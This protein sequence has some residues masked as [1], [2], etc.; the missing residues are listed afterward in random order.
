MSDENKLSLEQIKNAARDLMRSGQD[1]RTKLHE[2]TVRALT[3]GRLAEQEIKAVLGAITEGVSLG[4]SERAEEVRSALGDAL[5][6]V[7]DALVNAAEAMQLALGEVGTHA[8]DFADQ[9][10]KQGLDELK[11][12]EQMFLETVTR[13]GDGASGLVKQELAVLAEH[14]RRTG[15]GTGERVKLVSEELANR[16]RATAHEAGDAGLHAARV[17]GARVAATASTKLA[18]IAERLK[19]KA[20]ALQQD[21]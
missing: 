6:G 10:L 19:R 20:E 14:A 7:D 18:E 8:K 12:L 11:K 5:H 13:V 16:L 3:Q 15:T 4:A 2:L 17:I 21:K 1:V 9:D